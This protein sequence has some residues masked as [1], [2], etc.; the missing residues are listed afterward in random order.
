MKQK[1]EYEIR[2]LRNG[3]APRPAVTTDAFIAWFTAGRV[4]DYGYDSLREDGCVGDGDGFRVKQLDVKLLRYF[5][6]KA[7]LLLEGTGKR[8]ELIANGD[9]SSALWHVLLSLKRAGYGPGT[10]FLA[11][12]G[13]PLDEKP[14]ER[15]RDWFV[16]QLE[17]AWGYDEH[18]PRNIEAEQQ[19]Q[20]LRNGNWRIGAHARAAR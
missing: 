17:A 18:D 19:K 12:Q 9:R 14:R 16:D 15:G 13:S 7:A 10:A 4:N 8:E 11:V 2:L 6:P 1:W 20:A 3:Y 5:S